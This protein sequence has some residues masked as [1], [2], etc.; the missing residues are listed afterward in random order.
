MVGQPTVEV[1]LLLPYNESWLKLELGQSQG[2]QGAQSI[3]LLILL[4]GSLG[5]STVTLMALL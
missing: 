4:R 5:P 3:Y 2:E 1:V